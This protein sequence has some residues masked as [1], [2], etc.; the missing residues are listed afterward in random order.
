MATSERFIPGTGYVHDLTTAEQFI[1][2]TGYSF[3]TIVA[4]TGNLPPS[5]F[6]NANRVIKQ[7]Y[8]QC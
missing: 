3:V 8:K 1:P 5:I 7:G 6:Q 4:S 2:G